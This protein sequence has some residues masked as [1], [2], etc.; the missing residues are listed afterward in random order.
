M[1]ASDFARP[2]SVPGAPRESSK[3]RNPLSRARIER[4]ADRTVAAFG[5]VFGLQTIPSALAQQHALV[6]PWGLVMT[7]VIFGGIVVTV[8]LAILQR[9]VKGAMA[10]LAVLYLVAIVTWPFVVSDPAAFTADKPWIW[11]LCNVFTAFAAVAYP[12]WLAVV[13]TLIA[14]IAYGVVRALPAGGGVGAELAGLDAV[15]AIILGGAILAIIAMMRQASSGVD[16]AQSQ[17]LARYATAVRQ[18]ATEVERVQVDAIVH[19]SVLTTLLS[20]ASARTPEQKEL[21][22]TMAADAIGHLHAAEASGPEDQSL[23]GLDR[24]SD[25]LVTAA[26]AFSS[27]FAIEVQ[28]VEVHSLPVNVAEAVYSASVQAMVN[29]MQHAGGPEVRRSISIR[30]GT[31]SATVHIVVRDEGKGFAADEVPAERLGLRVSIRDRL[32]KVGGRARIESE[33]GAGTTVVILWP[34]SDREPEVVE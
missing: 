10:V 6:Q 34:S 2:G 20:A 12:L 24:L 17:A 15:Y 27:P 5:L 16:A 29:S 23:V 28:D 31:P 14:P 7:I 30:G 18:H 11:F 4:I 9:W 1:S 33:P 22:A 8:L 19:D 3:P 32:A 26:N 25:R 21:A 13:Y